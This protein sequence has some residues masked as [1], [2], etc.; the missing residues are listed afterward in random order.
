MSIIFILFFWI[1]YFSFCCIYCT[2]SRM[3]IT[4]NIYT[5]K[6][7]KKSL[8]IVVERHGY[9]LITRGWVGVTPCQQQGHR[10]V[11]SKSIGGIHCIIIGTMTN[12]ISRV[13]RLFLILLLFP[14]FSFRIIILNFV[15]SSLV[16]LRTTA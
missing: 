13:F 11:T 9:R 6:I 5:Y 10:K 7:K 15:W 12:T 1:I 8:S 2:W 3:K 16:R 14:N 4:K